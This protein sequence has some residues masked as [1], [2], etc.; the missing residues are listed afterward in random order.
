MKK[1]LVYSRVSTEEQASEGRHSLH[2]QER[3]CKTAIGELGYVLATEGVYEDAGKSGTSI[4]RPGLQD[5]LLRIQE[6]KSICAVF[7]QD[8]DRLAR[9]ARDHLMIK[10]LLE[11]N[12]VQIISISQPGIVDT[13]EGNFMDIV[14]AGINQ[15][16]SEITGRKVIK[17]M[18]TRFK[19]GW[20]PTKAPLGYLNVGERGNEG[21]RIIIKDPAKAP[22]VQELFKLYAL[23]T[24]SIFSIRDILYK[25]GLSSYREK[26]PSK[27]ILLS[28]LENTFY[29]GEMKWGGLV[30][31][32]KHEPL[33]TKE[34][35][36]RCRRIREERNKFACRERKYNFLYNG[37]IFSAT[38]GRRYIGEKILNKGISYYRCH[39]N[40]DKPVALED[41]PIRLDKFDQYVNDAFRGIEFTEQFAE[42]VITKVRKIYEKKKKDVSKGKLMLENRKLAINNKLE[43]A[44]EKLIS[45]TLAD[46][47]F[48]RIKIRLRNQIENIEDEIL[49][50]EQ[51]RN[52][53]IDVI[54]QVLALIK[55]IG[56]SYETAP[57]E[58]K[59]VYLSLFWER[60]EVSER[61]VVN[62][63]PTRIVKALVAAGSLALNKRQKPVQIEQAF[64]HKS[65]KFLDEAGIKNIRL[66]R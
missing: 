48:T 22:L 8:T 15:L 21:K 5:M 39:G 4:T 13:P 1:A 65:S 47:E 32:G 52:V 35:Y 58:L 40:S 14:I 46:D 7:V 11:K 12:N 54:Q 63:Q 19:D 66:R 45:G 57:V 50:I 23:G 55:N 38:N 36:E 6:D 62:A 49:K 18:H 3:L 31:R 42:K 27:S 59:R 60:F 51:S 56:Q 29:Y 33:I 9:N 25:K 44:E 10:A 34:L 24:Y 20:Y 26:K 30:G 43:T 16:Q 53:Q 61:K 41:K 28:M 37:L 64:A 17:S 2:T